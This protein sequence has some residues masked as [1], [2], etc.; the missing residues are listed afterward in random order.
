[1]ANPRHALPRRAAATGSA[2]ARGAAAPTPLHRRLLCSDRVSWTRRSPRSVPREGDPMATDIKLDQNNGT[3]LVIE[4]SVLKTTAA[5]FMLDSPVRRRGG[6]SPHR[7]ALVH[8]FQDGLTINFAGDYPGGVTVT[9]NLAVTGDVKIAGT[10]VKAAL[11]SLQATL[12]SLKLTSSD[13]HPR[14]D[15]LEMTVASLVELV[16]AA[17]IPPWRSKTEVEE[18]DDMGMSTQSAEQLGLVVRFEIDQLNPDFDHEEVI[19]ITPAAG[20]LVMRGS[21][22]V[23]RINLQG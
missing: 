5:D 18:G 15:A 14:L 2:R 13:M 6:P 8:D 22:V 11:D 23:V 16:G 9:G 17:V 4:G 19:S 21:T 7:R 10:A 12:D 20:T 3:W 1:M